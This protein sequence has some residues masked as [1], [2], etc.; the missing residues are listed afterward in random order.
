MTTARRLSVEQLEEIRQGLLSRAHNP[1]NNA[2]RLLAHIEA[3]EA[4]LVALRRSKTPGFALAN[5]A[6]E[7]DR[8]RAELAQ[9]RAEP[10]PGCAGVCE[11]CRE[12]TTAR[13]SAEAERD[14]LRA[15]N[16]KL[17]EA[18]ESAAFAL[19]M[20]AG[21]A[22]GQTNATPADPVAYAVLSNEA[23]NARAALGERSSASPAKES[24]P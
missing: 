17:R 19:E 23:A 18:L 22:A 8:L 24:K 7:R 15:E 1:N 5:V 11:G 6:E 13:E 16:A 9:L 3:L 2:L 21:N 14:W 4:E 20:A 12:E 10:C